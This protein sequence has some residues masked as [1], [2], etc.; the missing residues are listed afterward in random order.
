MPKETRHRITSRE[1]E[2]TRFLTITLFIKSSE[3]AHE[4]QVR[5]HS[6]VGNASAIM[7]QFPL[8]DP[9]LCFLL[10]E[11]LKVVPLSGTSHL[12]YQKWEPII[13]EIGCRFFSSIF[14][15]DVLA[16][17]NLSLQKAEREGN[18]AVDSLSY[19]AGIPRSRCYEWRTP[20][21]REW[22]DYHRRYTQYGDPP[23]SGPDDGEGERGA[24]RT[25][26]G[27]AG[28]RDRDVAI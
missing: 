7:R 22:A 16:Y 27:S 19:G 4:Y 25:T 6:P 23:T 1:H 28:I 24:R 10:E 15:G 9:L 3:V 2:G 21:D 13:Q 18:R 11:A 12:I 17:Y 20:S 26:G 5:M 14:Q 8:P